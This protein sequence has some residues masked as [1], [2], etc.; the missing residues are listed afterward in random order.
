M[1]LDRNLKWLAKPK[2][3][4]GPLQKK[5]TKSYFEYIMSKIFLYEL[6]LNI[7]NCAFCE[8]RTVEEWKRSASWSWTNLF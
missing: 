2:I 6:K 8:V 3:F 7:V 5:F 1:I 4:T